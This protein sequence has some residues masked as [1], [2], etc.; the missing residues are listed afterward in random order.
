MRAL[1]SQVTYVIILIIN[2]LLIFGLFYVHRK[3]CTMTDEKEQ[4]M[5]WQTLNKTIEEADFVFDKNETACVEMSKFVPLLE[6]DTTLL[7]QTLTELLQNNRDLCAT[8]ICF[9][10]STRHQNVYLMQDKNNIERASFNDYISELK[11]KFLKEHFEKNHLQPFWETSAIR[12]VDNQAQINLFVPFFD[13]SNRLKGFVGFNMSLARMDNLLRSALTYYEKDDQAF[14]F[15]MTPDGIAV[16]I[17]GEVI[18]KNENLFKISE[19]TNDDALLSTLYNMRNGETASLKLKSAVIRSDNMFFHKSMKNKQLSIALS[20]YENQS[21]NAWMHFFIIIMVALILSFGLISLWL[22]WYW[23]SRAKMADKIEQS[24]REMENGLA[25]TLYP[26]SLLHKDLEKMWIRIDDMRKILN[27][28]DE[29]RLSNAKILERIKNEKELAQYIRHYFYSPVFQPRKTSFSHKIQKSGQFKYISDVGG[30]FHDYFNVAP[31]HVCFVAGTVSRPKK[32]I[33]NI[34]TSIDI[35]MTMSLIRSHLKAYSTLAECVFYLNNDLYSQNGGN[36]TVNIFIGVINCKTGTFEFFSAGAPTH[37]RISH[38]SIFPITVQH[39]LPLAS[40]K[41]E[42]YETGNRDLFS[43]EMVLIH[44]AGVLSRHNANSDKYGQLRLQKTMAAA[45]MTN[46]TIFLEQIVEDIT[47]FTETQTSQVDD[48]TL[49]AI[50][51]E[52][53]E[54]N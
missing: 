46:P 9:Y 17:A 37:Y 47:K 7:Y 1:F 48:Y 22:W 44:T 13:K 14:L 51:Y 39:G 45:N 40:R 30:D 11:Q 32:S 52:E 6:N 33:S 20:Y 53:K 34:Q 41:N 54:E 27:K 5:A 49:L 18:E 15:M 16:S 4:Q 26:S 23:K 12:I 2:V 38:R 28:K 29:N 25:M 35:L 8:F 43:G 31:H 10:D 19:I 36:F 3:M 21:M 24:I 42:K 50:K